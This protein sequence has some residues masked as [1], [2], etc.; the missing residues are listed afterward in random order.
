M[1]EE[2][3]KDRPVV[4]EVEPG[5]YAWCGCGK[6][7]KEPFCDGSHAGTGITPNV[8]R[9]EE[10]KT[11]AWCTCRKTGGAPFCDGSHSR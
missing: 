7:S 11:V 9:I 6:T 2:T 3:P 8:V 1:S 10:K 4:A 5:V